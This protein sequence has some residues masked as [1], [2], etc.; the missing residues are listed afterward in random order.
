MV[1]V[2]V[3]C[4]VSVVQVGRF[5]SVPRWW[6]AFD[7][8]KISEQAGIELENRITSALTRVRIDG[9]EDWV[10]AIDQD[11]LNSWLAYR[12]R[13]TI[14]S[15]VDQD[16]AQTIGEIRVVLAPT[17]MTIGTK[18]DHARG[19]SIVWAVIEPGTNSDG[20]FS[21]PYQARVSW[22]GADSFGSCIGIPHKRPA[23]TGE[24][25]SW[26]WAGRADPGDP[27]W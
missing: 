10:A 18:L 23:R 6:S 13:D 8:S 15:F 11:Q 26:G 25:G 5:D 27:H 2:V 9:E 22:L 3:L 17:G 24:R 16:A 14:E 21:V 19:S 4:V 1:L 12:L 7:Q 20:R